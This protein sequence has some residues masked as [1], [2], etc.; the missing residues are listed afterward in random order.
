MY[1]NYRKID[2]TKAPI[3]I[4]L[5][6]RGLGKT[7]GAVF[8]AVKKFVSKG[9]RFVYVVETLEMVKVLTQ[10]K[11]EK[12]F[13]LIQKFLENSESNKYKKLY[14][15]MFS[16]E[17]TEVVEADVLNKIQGGTIRIKGET[18]GY[19]LAYNDFANIKR[20]N[21]RDVGY[22]IFDEFIPEKVDIRSLE[23]ARKVVSI[24]Q[25]VARLQDIVIYMLANAIRIN[26]IILSKLGLDNSKQ[27]DFKILKDK[28]GPL[29]A[30]HFVD[31]NE[32][33]DFEVVADK[34]VS[35]RFAKIMQEDN[36]DKN[37]FR[38]TLN[39]EYR[40]PQPAKSSSM[41]F[42]LHGGM[43]SIRVHRTK[44]YKEYYILNDYGRNIG[45][46]YCFDKKYISPNVRYNTDWRE[47]LITQFVK[48][49]IKFD[50]TMSL[51]IFKDILKLEQNT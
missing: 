43:G 48:G 19:L 14:N 26:D 31:N 35:G 25:T 10:N 9:K 23:N 36:L 12:F 15:K 39:E 21:F 44:D 7:F 24:V 29:I 34:S 33:P 50:T 22:I 46:R 13:A 27:G 32:Y 41:I 18:A 20:N 5:S 8:K 17:N 37:T 30:F 42:C 11:G 6:R 45:S 16:N 1:Y 51:L 3:R 2:G 28:Y 40:I 38:V 4:I 49:N 47:I